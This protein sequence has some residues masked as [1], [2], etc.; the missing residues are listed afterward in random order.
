MRSGCNGFRLATAILSGQFPDLA[1]DDGEGRLLVSGDVL[2]AVGGPYVLVMR[3]R[4]QLRK[5][6]IV[7]IA[8]NQP[9]TG[10]LKVKTVLGPERIS[11]GD[12]KSEEHG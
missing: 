7:V 5:V 10:I 1:E 11:E 2:P 8:K 4:R 12:I 3:K 9:I 6:W